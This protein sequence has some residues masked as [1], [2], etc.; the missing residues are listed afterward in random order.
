MST[1]LRVTSD[2]YECRTDQYTTTMRW[3]MFREIVT[4]QEF[5]LFFVNRQFAA[6]LPNNAFD[7][8]QQA[9]LG[10]FLAARQRAGAS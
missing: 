6:F 4:T 5:W 7:S 1:T 10:A 2:G 3:S 9:E 8:E